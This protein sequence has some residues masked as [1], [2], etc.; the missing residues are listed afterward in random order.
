MIT[1]Y[2]F[3]P[4]WGTPNPGQFNTKLETYLRM[5]KIPYEVEV[6][7]PL[8]A[9]KGKL[10]FIV[11]DG[12]KITDSRFIIEYLKEKYSDPLD[13][14]L[15]KEQCAIML[16]MQRLLEEHLYWI[17]M[18]TRW[19]TSDKNLQINNEA[20][21]G[22]LPPIIRTIAAL[23]YKPII[24]KQIYGQGTGR[25]KAND[26]YH[27]GELDLDALSVF[28]ADKSYFMGNKVTSLDASAFGILINTITGPIE[29]PLKEYGK[30][31]TNLIAYCDR[32]MAEFYPELI[33]PKL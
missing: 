3:A 32:M 12:Q 20:L 31:K 25:H 18:Y 8:K 24:R 6:T 5:T 16:G 23:I 33:K 19:Q 7:L 10:P 11:D 26:I 1:L 14:E 4:S 13:K 17:G 15:T 22:V 30:N 9:P 2:Q 21:F 29:S 28:L 27:L